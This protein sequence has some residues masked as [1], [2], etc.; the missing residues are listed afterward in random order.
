MNK[1]K[2][3]LYNFILT[4]SDRGSFLLFVSKTIF[5]FIVFASLILF[6]SFKVGKP[7]VYYNNSTSAPIG[8]YVVSFDRDYEYN[9]YLIM[10]LPKQYGKLEKG[11]L[12]LKQIKGFPGDIYLSRE[13]YVEVGG[14]RY[15]VKKHPILPHMP[16]GSYMVPEGHLFLLNDREDSFDGRYMGP[17]KQE[18][19]VRKVRLLI[20]REKLY[21]FEKETHDKIYDMFPFLEK[22]TSKVEEKVQNEPITKTDNKET[23]Q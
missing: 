13:D 4:H 17:V 14:C 8:F 2:A 20:D 22:L 10:K 11:H 1:I 19:V 21:E 5:L 9:D 16:I 23:K 6:I 7:L 3:W 15:N 18:C 12:V